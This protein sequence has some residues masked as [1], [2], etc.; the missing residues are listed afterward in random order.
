MNGQSK[1]AC[2]CWPLDMA[3]AVPGT[4]VM[5]ILFCFPHFP[6]NS[7]NLAF[8]LAHKKALTGQVACGLGSLWELAAAAGIHQDAS[9]VPACHFDVLVQPTSAGG[10]LACRVA[11]QHWLSFVYRQAMLASLPHNTRPLRTSARTL[12]ACWSVRSAAASRETT[13]LRNLKQVGNTWKQLT[14]TGFVPWKMHS[15]AWVLFFGGSLQP[16]GAQVSCTA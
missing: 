15:G 5:G 10:V 6:S 2:P 14:S 4:K 13:P 12:V 8:T 1:H 11:P 16:E 9:A 7:P 3:A